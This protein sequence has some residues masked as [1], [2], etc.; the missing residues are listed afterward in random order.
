MTNV[1]LV[2]DNSS[3]HKEDVVKE[4]CNGRCKYKFLPPYSPNLNP[5]E[6]IFGIFKKYMKKELATELREQLLET[7]NLPWGQKTAV[8]QSILDPA[9]VTND[10]TK[11]LFMF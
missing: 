7:F 3:V 5:I 8:K 11:N 4:L 1:C 10:T 6:N 9:F 2:M